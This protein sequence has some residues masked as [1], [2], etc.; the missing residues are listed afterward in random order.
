MSL[1]RAIQYII[2]SAREISK[3]IAITIIAVDIRGV[4]PPN[5][6]PI[7]KTGAEIAKT[8]D[9]MGI[10]IAVSH[11]LFISKVLLYFLPREI[12]AIRYIIDI[13]IVKTYSKIISGLRKGW[14]NS[15]N[16]VGLFA[17]PSGIIKLE[18][19]IN[20]IETTEAYT[21]SINLFFI[22][23]IITYDPPNV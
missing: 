19:K 22:E 1:L 18:N 4:V 12:V 16:V 6:K 3:D 2:T 23:V 9:M 14:S 21:P 7:A 15:K 11:A 20:I 13:T 5:I 17:N 10:N 8:T